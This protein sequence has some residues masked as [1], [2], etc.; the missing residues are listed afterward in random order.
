MRF[1]SCLPRS[2]ILLQD[3]VP[4]LLFVVGTT[5][6]VGASCL[7]AL[8]LPSWCTGF[9]PLSKCLEMSRVSGSWASWHVPSQTWKVPDRKVMQ[10]N[11]NHFNTLCCERIHYYS[12]VPQV[13]EAS[14]SK[15]FCTYS[16]LETIVCIICLMEVS[17]WESGCADLPHDLPLLHTLWERESSNQSHISKR[18][19]YEDLQKSG[20]PPF[21]QHGCWENSFC[22]V[23]WNTCNRTPF[24]FLFSTWRCQSVLL[25]V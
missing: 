1:W 19:L 15:C 16:F 6:S 12:F 25:W 7:F 21:K 17:V 24:L 8:G 23:S 4:D 22:S 13:F 20:V 5:I 3:F 2:S 10:Y 11:S 14:R 9:E 18:I